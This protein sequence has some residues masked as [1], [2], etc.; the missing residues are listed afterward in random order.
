MS[1]KVVWKTN[2]QDQLSLLPPSYDDLVP[3]NH[4]VRIVNTIVDQIDLSVLEKEYKGGGT[5]SY[6]PRVLLKIL[7]YAYLRNLY[8]SRKIEEALG[9]NLH[10]IW[11][12]GTAKPDHN[13]ISNFRS[14]KLKG[15][16]KK[17]FNQVVVLLAE[18][19]YLSLK[20]IYVDG[21]KIE[22]NANRYTFVWAK[23]ITTSRKRI[24]KQLKE[25]WNYVEKVYVNQE[26]LP[27]T[28]SFEAIDPEKVSQ[29]IAYINKTLEGKAIDKK[30]KQK[31][32]YAK[33]NWP[34]NLKKYKEQ[35]KQMGTRNSMSKT[36]PDATFMR[37]KDDHMQ[38]GQLKPG[39]NVQASTNNQF[40]VN[41]TLAQT[42]ADTT[43]LIDH[44]DEFIEAYQQ[45]PEQ[46]TADAGYGSEEN[47]VDL[48]DKGIQAF[49][50]YNYFHKEQLDQKRGSSKK[51]FAGNKLHY[52]KAQDCYYC[53][54]GQA[55]KN[56]G[57]YTRE[58]KTGYIQT[59]N[60]YQAHNC[61]GCPMRGV[62]HKAKGN[63]IVERNHN[64][65]RLKAKAK[66]KLL[67][68]EGIAHRKQRCWD[69]EAVFGNIKQNMNFKRFLLRGIDKVETE[70]GLIAMAHNL[71]KVTLRA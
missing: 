37:M 69:V 8:S 55:M 49:V 19:G 51:P 22:A 32:N 62:C 43:T 66:E 21:T 61:L 59:I 5:S 25:L 14:G 54:M 13:T 70:I 2:N 6:H 57:S 11:L 15:H 39:Y 47:Y 68:P 35:E 46:L 58:T 42:T 16:F 36:D 20:D 52:N 41:Y 10:F 50:K 30:V 71:K 23:S 64:L 56:I 40:F 7:I 45:T 44:V 4:P 3:Q 48:E 26:H 24:E 29:T 34:K 27:N 17:I 67:S 31:L 18:Q 33:K 1:R 60:R 53:P 9:E 12:A 63:R 38:N 65:V 28:P